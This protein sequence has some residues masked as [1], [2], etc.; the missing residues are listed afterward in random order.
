M[1]LLQYT[2][3]L[4]GGSGQWNSCSTCLT[5]WGQWAVELPQYTASLPGG[6]GQWTFCNTLPHCLGA[7]GSG[8]PATHRL[9]AWG[10]WAVERTPIF[11]SL[12]TLHHRPQCPYFLVRPGP[13]RPPPVQDSSLGQRCSL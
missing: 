10:Q 2:T 13:P 3:S 4:L 5:A 12:W 8:P 7:M 1:D 9:T 6:S 11:E